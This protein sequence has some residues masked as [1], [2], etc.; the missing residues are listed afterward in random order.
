LCYDKD[1]LKKN[2]FEAY[3]A[4]KLFIR[5]ERGKLAHFL[6]AYLRW[7]DDYVDNIKIDKLEQEIFLHGQS[8]IYF[9]G[10]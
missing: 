7:V 1:S 2:N 4:T 8:K 5:G 10:N 9:Q 6:Y 3:F